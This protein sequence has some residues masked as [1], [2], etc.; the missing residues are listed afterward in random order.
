MPQ[1][2]TKHPQS[3]VFIGLTVVNLR[4]SRVYRDGNHSVGFKDSISLAAPDRQRVSFGV[5]VPELMV[6]FNHSG[7]RETLEYL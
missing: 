3:A 1:N 6:V 5:S 7:E 4:L 2:S